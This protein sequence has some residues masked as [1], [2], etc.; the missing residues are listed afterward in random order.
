MTVATRD[1]IIGA[2]IASDL[3]PELGGPSDPLIGGKKRERHF[4]CRYCQLEEFAAARQIHPQHMTAIDHIDPSNN[5]LKGKTYGSPKNPRLDID[6]LSGIVNM[7]TLTIGD[8]VDEKTQRWYRQ[9]IY[10]DLDNLHVVCAGHNQRKAGA[11][12]FHHHQESGGISFHTVDSE[13]ARS[14]RPSY[15]NKLH[16]TS[17]KTSPP[18]LQGPS[19]IIPQLT[20][21]SSVPQQQGGGGF[22]TYP[23]TQYGGP[24]PTPFF[25]QQGGSGFPTPPSTPYPSG[26][27]FVSTPQYQ[28]QYDSGFL[29]LPPAPYGGSLPTPP[30]QYQGSGGFP[31]QPSSPYS[32]GGSF[33]S[34]SQYPPQYG[35]GY[36][37]SQTVPYASSGGFVQAPQQHQHQSGGGFNPPFSQW[38][39]Q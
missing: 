14:G 27:G 13:A 17:H 6:K 1:A 32:S 2:A 38:G 33:A 16:S 37:T 3:A 10:N 28:P 20:S 22:P 34:T 5:F 7:G 8:D 35:G 25:Q 23:P 9:L 19:R 29:A 24:L 12:D 36:P 15:Y 11:I 30:F 4:H 21:S 18:L 39:H 31:T 26:G